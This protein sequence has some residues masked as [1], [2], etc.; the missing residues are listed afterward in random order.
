LND[1]DLID[2]LAR[3]YSWKSRLVNTRDG[4]YKSLLHEM[5]MVQLKSRRRGPEFEVLNFAQAEDVKTIEL[6]TKT[7]AGYGGGVGLVVGLFS[8]FFAEFVRRTRRSGEFD[9]IVRAYKGN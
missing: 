2:D 8:A 6:S 5:E 3:E 7:R 9:R 1:V 4:L